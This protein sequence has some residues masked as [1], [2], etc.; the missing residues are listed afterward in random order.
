MR[1]SIRKPYVQ[2]FFRNNRLLFAISVLATLLT[3]SINLV[4]AWMMQQV[5]DAVS[6]IPG[7]RS[8]GELTLYK[9]DIESGSK[10]AAKGGFTSVLAMPNTNPVA[11][12]KEVIEFINTRIKEKAIEE[13]RTA[14]VLH[15]T[16]C[17]KE[18][19]KAQVKQFLGL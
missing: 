4:L 16:V 15:D 3:G 2:Q 9:E 1:N 19:M 13:I 14:E 12:S 6:R 5:T 17:T 7:S 18:E 10:S 11:D 8:L